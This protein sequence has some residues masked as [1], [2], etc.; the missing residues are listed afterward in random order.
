MKTFP[1][2]K[3][4]IIR[5]NKYTSIYKITILILIIRLNNNNE[6][7]IEIKLKKNFK[8]QYLDEDT[9]LVL[10]ELKINHVW[11][12]TRQEEGW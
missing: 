7:T 12:W 10:F 11:D 3:K 9:G 6:W 1:S 2:V 5:N 8:M 4:K